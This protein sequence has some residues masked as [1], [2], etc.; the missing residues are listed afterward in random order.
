MRQGKVLLIRGIMSQLTSQDRELGFLTAIRKYPAIHI[1]QI[2]EGQWSTQN[3]IEAL[4]Q[5][6]RV[7]LG[8][9]QAVFAY[10]DLMALGAATSFQKYALRPLIV[11]YDGILE[12]QSA[13]LAGDIDATVTQD[14]GEMGRRAVLRLRQCIEQQVFHG[15]TDLTHASLLLAVRTLTAVSSYGQE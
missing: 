14:P 13:I 10:N 12:A 11:G 9:F 8:Q 6:S 3:T 5:L 15:D 2:I 4:Q 7:Q 1:E